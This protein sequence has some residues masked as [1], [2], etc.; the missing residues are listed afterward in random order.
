MPTTTQQ[1]YSSIPG[2]LF[3]HILMNLKDFGYLVS[4]HE[5][6]IQAGLG[7]LKNHGDLVTAYQACFLF[8]LLE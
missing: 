2:I 8:I 3:I 4:N 1:L 7:L 5:Y 6:R